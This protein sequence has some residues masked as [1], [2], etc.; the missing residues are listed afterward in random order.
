M[1]KKA[2]FG[3]RET[4]CLLTLLIITKIFFTSMITLIGL[5]GTAAW[6]TTLISGI[7]ASVGFTFVYLLIKRFPGNNLVQIFKKVAGKVLGSIIS[8]LFCGYFVFYTSS[9]LREFLEMV[10]AFY[11]PYTPPSFILITFLI[12]TALL[13]YLGLEAITRV[14]TFAFYVVITVIAAIILLVAPNYSLDDLFPI[15]GYGLK[16]TLFH[17]IFRSSA[18]GEIIFLAFIANSIKGG[19]KNIKKAG[20]WSLIIGCMITSITILCVLMIFEYVQGSENLSSF[21]QL[22]RIIYFNR[23]FQRF[24]SIFM[25]GWVF[26]SVINVTFAFFI[27]VYVFSNTFD[28]KYYRPLILPFLFITFVIAIM[29]ENLSQIIYFNINVIREYSSF[30]IFTVPILVLIAAVIFKKK[31]DFKNSNSNKEGDR[32]LEKS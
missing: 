18:Y 21:F 29:P 2:N 7:T 1:D 15:G 20:Y 26:A 14:S 30:F 32:N 8:L 31:G 16:P 17:G 22:S 6:Y 5:T 12:T 3:F 9:N 23:F 10:K 11:L 4:F 28:I 19:I 27:T 13:S 25:F 24:E